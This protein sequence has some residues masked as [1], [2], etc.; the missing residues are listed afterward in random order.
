MLDSFIELSSHPS[1]DIKERCCNYETCKRTS[2][3]G[4]HY[5]AN[6]SH[7]ILLIVMHM[8]DNNVFQHSMDVS[9]VS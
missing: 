7:F 9:N 5:N 2:D 8:N 1:H 4:F 3:H 6:R